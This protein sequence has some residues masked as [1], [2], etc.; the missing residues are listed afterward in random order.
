MKTITLKVSEEIDERVRYEAQ[1]Q[2]ISK[3]SLVRE[4]LASYLAEPSNSSE[5]SVYDRIKDLLDSDG[6]GPSDLSTNPKYMEDFGTDSLGHLQ[7]QR[8]SQK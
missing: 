8:R 1:R 6:E 7:L 2:G 4:A 5:P 3:S